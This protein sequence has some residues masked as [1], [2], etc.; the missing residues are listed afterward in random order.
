MDKVTDFANKNRDTIY[1]VVGVVVVL[2]ILYL[3]YR[4]CQYPEPVI[5]NM[6]PMYRQEYHRK[7]PEKGGER[8]EPF[9]DT[10]E[11]TKI[12]LFYAPW[13]PHCKHLMDGPDST[14]EKL[15]RKHGNR[16]GL[17][18]D[19]VNCDEKPDLATKFGI[20]G[21]PTILKLSGD[22]ISQ[23]DGERKL[24]SLEGFLNE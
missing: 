2:G 12:I 24:D 15:K 20:K 8:E 4:R 11:P 16:K 22:K 5:Y 21:F 23:Y 6:P 7:Q 3:V 13:C 9:T 10:K 17:M 14:W 19:Q 18:I 1:I